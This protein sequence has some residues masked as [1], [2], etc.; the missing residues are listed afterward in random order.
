[1]KRTKAALPKKHSRTTQAS[2]WCVISAPRGILG[3]GGLLLFFNLLA[4]QNSFEAGW[5][6]DDL[7]NIVNNR[8]IQI[9]SLSWQNLSFVLTSEIAGKR[10]LAYLSFAI[11]H[12]FS[13]LEVRA[14]HWTNFALHLANTLV[15]WVL[16]GKITACCL[17]QLDKWLPIAFSFFV[18]A[19]WSTNPLQTQA[20]TYVVQR[21]TLLAALFFLL[22]FVLYLKFRAS[23]S[24]KEKTLWLL[25]SSSSALLAFASK[26]NTFILPAVLAAYEWLVSPNPPRLLKR[27]RLLVGLAAA[28]VGFLLFLFV[29]Y[30]ILD[31]IL[32]GYAAREFTLFQR[33][34]TQPRVVVD[35]L[36]LFLLP[37]PSRMA[38]H[39]EVEIS[40][41][42]FSPATTLVAYLF[43][44]SMVTAAIFLR[45]RHPMA[46]FWVSWFFIT[47]LIESTVLPLELMFEHRLYLPSTGLVACIM[48]PGLLWLQSSSR[49]N[50]IRVL[51]LVGLTLIAGLWICWTVERNRVWS[52]DVTLWTDNL[53]K[54]PNSARVLN[55]LG[56]A[57]AA[58]GQTLLAEELFR[59]ALTLKPEF[60]EVRSNLALI[61]L[62]R[63]NLKQALHWL[64]GI[65]DTKQIGAAVFFNM[66]VIY[67]K[68][69]NF[70]K[71]IECYRNAF[72]RRRGYAEAF[73]NL[74]L[75]YLKAGSPLEARIC[76][77]DFLR[78]WNGDPT[79]PYVI[80]A[81]RQIALLEG[82]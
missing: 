56:T 50:W 28:N 47:L 2:T 52:D 38:L 73:Y 12:Y 74:A 45:R 35:Y 5:H 70:D 17:P 81:R 44:G 46:V 72:I 71:A 51:S 75:V 58:A 41:S 55:N 62:E 79:S 53:Q 68:Q 13:G 36:S 25:G 16:V 11:N 82:K 48:Y 14:Y 61:E 77:S 43:L 20:V 67:A 64:E 6:F 8:D 29:Q 22:S 76:F 69:G 49:Q 15:V 34:L 27:P 66:G 21:M 31:R 57:Q 60:T 37:L 26:E 39:H 24:P 33:I 54:Y 19:L 7:S 23:N 42:L 4:Y 78:M 1:M 59:K 32:G 80:E 10:P 40:K 63:G 65:K 30:K 3:L 18:A 9:R